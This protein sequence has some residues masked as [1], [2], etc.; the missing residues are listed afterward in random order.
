M[1][2]AILK[3]ADTNL[4]GLVPPRS[5]WLL[6]LSRRG[7][8]G[9]RVPHRHGREPISV[10]VVGGIGTHTTFDAFDVDTFAIL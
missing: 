1:V 6:L 7:G 8:E 3:L 2:P 4:D 10:G 5:L 9:A